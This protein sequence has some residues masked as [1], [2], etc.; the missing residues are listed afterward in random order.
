MFMAAS[1][2]DNTMKIIASAAGVPS[3]VMGDGVNRGAISFSADFTGTK[4]VIIQGDT[5]IIVR[6]LSSNIDFETGLYNVTIQTWNNL[7]ARSPSGQTLQQALNA[8]A[9]TFTGYY[10]SIA[11]N[12]GA[13]I[14]NFSNG[15]LTSIT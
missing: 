4:K 10:G 1:D 8:K 7:V 15:I 11:I 14:L 9:N 13:N 12:G 3:L 5:G 6:S 2:P